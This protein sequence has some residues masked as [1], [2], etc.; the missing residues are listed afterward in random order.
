MFGMAFILKLMK[1]ALSSGSVQWSLLH[2]TFASYP[3]I[4]THLLAGTVLWDSGKAI[5][6][7]IIYCLDFHHSMFEMDIKMDDGQ[8]PK[9]QRYQNV[10][11]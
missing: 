3:K 8:G 7:G 6:F 5:T 10:V 11:C 9:L 2:C 1:T 4:C